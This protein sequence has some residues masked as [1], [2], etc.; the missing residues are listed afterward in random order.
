MDKTLEEIN[1]I[2]N[3]VSSH[4][5]DMSFDQLLQYTKYHMNDYYVN[6]ASAEE[7]DELYR[8]VG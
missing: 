8:S 5:D 1:R 6:V 2:E 7:F 3:T 4:V